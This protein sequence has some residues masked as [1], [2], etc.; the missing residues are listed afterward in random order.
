MITCRDIRR[1]VIL[2]VLSLV[3]ILAHLAVAVAQPQRPVIFIPGILGSRLCENSVSLWGATGVGSL[4]NFAKLELMPDGGGRTIA[5]CGL[6]NSINLLGPF[7]VS[8]QYDD[9]MSE[10]DKLGYVNASTLFVFDYDWRK[11]NF[12]TAKL[13][14]SFI[15]STPQLR[16]GNFDVVAHSMGGL[17]TRIYLSDHE[18]TSRIR[19]I[20]FL[21]TPFEGSMNALATLSEGWGSFKNRFA[22]GIEAIRRVVLS[23]PAMY[24]LF[25]R[26]DTCCRMGSETSFNPFNLFDSQLWLDNDWLPPEYRSGVRLIRFKEDLTR[27]QTLRSILAKPSPEVEKV[28]VA[29]DAFATSLYLYV[30]RDNRSWKN[31]RFSKSRGDGTVPVWSAAENFGTLAGTRPSFAEHATIFTDQGVKN[32]LL[33]ELVSNMPPPVA[34]S[35]A[36]FRLVTAG[37]TKDVN[38]IDIG[39]QPQ[40]TAPG[41]TVQLSVSVE[42]AQSVGRGDFLP[43][44]HYLG[45]DGPVLLKLAEMTSD[46]DLVARRLTF[47]AP[48]VTPQRE[49]TWQVDTFFPGQGHHAAY[50]E[51]WIPK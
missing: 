45:P 49:G 13:L 24:E 39:V 2:S 6:V 31:W 11:S 22:G 44:A 4:E 23:F 21:G 8:H 28:M 40:T 38:L 15:Q 34:T 17:V 1:A 42:F 7:W 30:Q 29:G 35:G 51:T 19:K 20:V 18:R 33:R 16:N 47:A 41:T 43:T 50:F 27:A 5:S 10:F 14:D 9:I 25:P 36:L 3:W 12:E 46:Q 48:I 32:V 26:Y 37:G